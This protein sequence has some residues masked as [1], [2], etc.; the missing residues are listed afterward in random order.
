MAGAL[1]GMVPGSAKVTPLDRY[2]AKGRA[3]GG[4]RAHRFLRGEDLLQLAWAGPEPARAVGSGGQSVTLPA[5]DE[6]RDGS[7][8]ALPAPVAAIG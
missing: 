4:V 3:T 8:Q 6:R 1:P 7:G 5:V 2:P